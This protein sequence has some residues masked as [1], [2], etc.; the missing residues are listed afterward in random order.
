M[1]ALK[2]FLVLFSFMGLLLVGCS[3]QSQSPVSPVDQ[4]SLQKPDLTNFTF[5]H[6]PP[7]PP[8]NPIIDPGKVKQVGRNWIMKDVGVTEQVFSDDPLINGTMIHYLSARMDIETG[9]GP[10]HGSMVLTPDGAEGGVWE[11]KY[12]GY[13]SKMPGS[14]VYF[15]LPLK[16]VAHGKGGTIDGMQSFFNTNI[17][18][19][20]TPPA[21]WYGGGEGFYKSH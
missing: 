13:R 5:S 15:I 8:A 16:V 12:E 4:G 9:E 20:G 19:W 10:V 14:D 18:A 6:H 3:D 2:C 21:G 1:K 17:T 7:L 11:G